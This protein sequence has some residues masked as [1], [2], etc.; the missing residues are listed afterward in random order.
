MPQGMT[1]YRKFDKIED[2]EPDSDEDEWRLS[3]AEKKAKREKRRDELIQHE[4][5]GYKAIDEKLK[6]AE[7]L[8]PRVAALLN[9]L[10]SNLRAVVPGGTHTGT[11]AQPGAATSSNPGGNRCSGSHKR[12]HDRFELQKTNRRPHALHGRR[13]TTDPLVLLDDASTPVS[14]AE[15]TSAGRTTVSKLWCTRRTA[16]P[17]DGAAD[18]V[19]G[20][21]PPT[22][23]IGDQKYDDGAAN[24]N[25]AACS[26][27]LVCI[28]VDCTVLP[29]LQLPRRQR[30]DPL[31]RSS[32][33]TRALHN[34]FPVLSPVVPSPQS[35]PVPWPCLATETCPARRRHPPYSTAVR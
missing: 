27:F 1:D 8:P 2:Y 20:A 4:L 30:R 5:D 26:S 6:V 34:F 7:K 12:R 13:A 28:A 18:A 3:E 11:S 21:Q 16:R 15:S 35:D 17:P 32:P 10:D 23:Q 31:F 29:R 9:L 25:T 33:P 19:G 22:I 14:T 24:D